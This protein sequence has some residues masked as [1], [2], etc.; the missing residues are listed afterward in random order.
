MMDEME[1]RESTQVFNAYIKA[2]GSRTD[3]AEKGVE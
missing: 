3:Y 2:L 1:F